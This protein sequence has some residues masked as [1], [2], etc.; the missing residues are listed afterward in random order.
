MTTIQQDDCNLKRADGIATTLKSS[1]SPL[2]TVD[3]TAFTWIDRQPGTGA[4]A[5]LRNSSAIKNIKHMT[6]DTEHYQ[7]LIKAD[8]IYKR[9]KPFNQIKNL[10][11]TESLGV[12]TA[13]LRSFYYKY[14]AETPRR[15]PGVDGTRTFIMQRFSM[16]ANE[17]DSEKIITFIDER[18]KK[19]QIFESELIS[20]RADERFDRFLEKRTALL[21]DIKTKFKNMP[22]LLNLLMKNLETDI[23]EIMTALEKK[24]IMKEQRVCETPWRVFNKM[25]S[26]KEKGSQK[27]TKP[28]TSK[29]SKKGKAG[30]PNTAYGKKKQK[31]FSK[32]STGRK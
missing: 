14:W 12:G 23:E 6:Q 26:E 22:T 30:G 7:S 21:N 27:T 11:R 31:D 19:A 5:A 29:K 2:S 3:T 1:C 20:K 32:K 28:S 15:Y 13:R 25:L 17:I 10:T 18:N 16:Q 9:E 24:L 8:R 4:A